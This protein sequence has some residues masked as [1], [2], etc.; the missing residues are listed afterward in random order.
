MR[1]LTAADLGIRGDLQLLKGTFSV[2]GDQA[3]VRIDI[4]QGVTETPFEVVKNLVLMARAKGDSTRWI[5]SDF[6]LTKYLVP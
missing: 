4:I 1:T 5:R 2:A 6:E 3:T